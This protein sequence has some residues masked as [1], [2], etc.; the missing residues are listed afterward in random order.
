[1][2]QHYYIVARSAD[3]GWP[4]GLQG[5]VGIRV[6]HCCANS[7]LEGAGRG[8]EGRGGGGGGEEVGPGG[9]P[10]QEGNPLY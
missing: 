6:V 2:Y 9:P 10:G 1:M 7:C 8:L 4:A 3:L 5:D